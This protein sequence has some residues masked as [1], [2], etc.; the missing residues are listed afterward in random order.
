MPGYRR[1][2]GRPS[3][4]AQAPGR[5]TRARARQERLSH[6]IDVAVTPEQRLAATFDALRSAAKRSPARGPAALADAQQQ[7]ARLLAWVTERGDAA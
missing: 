2:A 1:V 4:S 5:P 7:L 6:L 3:R